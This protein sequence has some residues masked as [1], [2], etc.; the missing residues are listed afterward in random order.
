MKLKFFSIS[1]FI[2]L[3]ALTGN[4]QQAA[5][6]SPDKHGTISAA[7]GGPS[8]Q[9]PL[10][11]TSPKISCVIDVKARKV[12]STKAT[13]TAYPDDLILLEVTNPKEFMDTR[14]ADRNKIVL[15]AGG[16]PLTG[17]T[18]DLFNNIGKEDFKTTDTVMWIP[19]FLKRDSSTKAAWDHLYKFASSWHQNQLK[20]NLTVAWEGM[21]PVKVLKK[22]S[23]KTEITIVFFSQTTFIIMI[24]I[25]VILLVGLG[26]LVVNT[27][28]LRDG[29]T[30]AY[31]L[32][33]T[34][35]AFWTILVL[36]GFIYSLLLTS[37]PS[38]LNTSILTLLG[39]SIGTSGVASYIDYFR[40]QKKV[41]TT[42]VTKSAKGFWR[43]ILGDGTSIN[44]QR[45]QT[46][47][48]NVVLG[49][50]Y[51]IYTF[52]NKTMPEIPDVLLMLAGVSSLSYVAAKP[53]EAS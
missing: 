22:D 43:D 33:Q 35:L 11:P 1:V 9:N 30:G 8:K 12:D 38:T 16:I 25:Y 42:P 31:S 14:P 53:T 32:A 50:Y 17:I 29:A 47:A 36:G 41:G 40:K 27:D 2:I 20:I 6:T 24:M 3:Y 37:I 51:T 45:F 23:A 52:H 48:W 21:L 46:V 10:P 5:A 15:Y 13:K 28:I 26:I 19:F 4:C 39:I 7:S 49:V 34:Q 18:S 44:M